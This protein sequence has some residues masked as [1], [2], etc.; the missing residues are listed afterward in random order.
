LKIL[1]DTSVW[2]DYFNGHSSLECQTLERYLRADADLA[3][4][5]VVVAEFFQG[6]RDPRSIARLEPYFL[7]MVLLRPK[8]PSSYLSAAA[9]YRMLRAQGVTVR[10]TIDCLIV[11]LAL[12]GDA[13][14]LAKD[15]DIHQIL[16]SGLCP[17]R[18]APRVD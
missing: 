3:T 12:E 7:D 11:Q 5:G 6:L 2:V 16:A 10:S 8:E 15:R 1:V 4:C 14:V 17:V 9:L 18:S 13:F